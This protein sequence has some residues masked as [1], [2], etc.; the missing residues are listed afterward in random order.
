MQ[1]PIPIYTAPNNAEAQL[2]RVLLEEEGIEAKAVDDLALV[3][4]W[5]MG[6][7]PGDH[8]PMVFVDRSQAEAAAAV[9]RQYEERLKQE[10]GGSPAPGNDALDIEVACEKCG[11]KSLFKAGQR[12]TIQSCPHCGAYLDVGA[13]PPDFN[14]EDSEA[15]KDSDGP[16]GSGG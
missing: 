7:I 10:R 6:T 1:N 9:I 5:V 15:G 8:Q 14:T 3:G 12:G 16:P 11:K 4:L 2:V 13:P